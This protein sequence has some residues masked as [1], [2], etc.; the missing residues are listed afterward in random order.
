MSGFD[1]RIPGV[2]LNIFPVF[3]G[4]WCGHQNLYSFFADGMAYRSL[5][6]VRTGMLPNGRKSTCLWFYALE[7]DGFGKIP[8]KVDRH[9]RRRSR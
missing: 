2:R 1:S 6:R 3:S 8:I 9:H 7:V 4:I 5:V